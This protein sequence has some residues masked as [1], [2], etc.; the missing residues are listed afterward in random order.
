MKTQCTSIRE[1]RGLR[2]TA[3]VLFGAVIEGS[4]G[5]LTELKDSQKKT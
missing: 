3:E 2:C 4:L 5:I 1:Q